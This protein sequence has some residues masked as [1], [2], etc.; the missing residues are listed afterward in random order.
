MGQVTNLKEKFLEY[1]NQL[2]SYGLRSERFY[3]DY[4]ATESKDPE[5]M[6]EWLEAAF[7]A[8]AEAMA[9]DTLA[10]LGDYATA[11]A[12]VEGQ[13]YTSTQ[14]FDV[15]AENLETYY[16][17][18]FGQNFTN[19]QQSLDETAMKQ[20]C[21]RMIA[22]LVGPLLV[23][24]WWNSRNRAFDNQTPAGEW[25]RNP[26]RVYRYLQTYCYR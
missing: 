25:I 22:A 16:Q 19:T 23:D 26:Q 24:D 14:A 1:F 4:Y 11:M 6:V 7:M 21:N 10:T 3:E 5:R 9:H 12:G 18:L 15:S 17:Q 13:K 8:G 20:E 2:E